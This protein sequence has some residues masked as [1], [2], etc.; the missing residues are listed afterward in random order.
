[1]QGARR[2]HVQYFENNGSRGIYQDGW[3]AAAFGPLVPWDTA[4]SAAKLKDWDAN[5]DV[6]ELYDLRGDFSQAED[7]AAT[8]PSA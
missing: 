5:K 8:S 4:G 2:K 6:W 3:Y 1:M 7:L